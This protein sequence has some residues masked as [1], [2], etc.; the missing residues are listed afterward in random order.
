MSEASSGRIRFLRVR[1]E[2]ALIRSVLENPQQSIDGHDAV[3][4]AVGQYQA[5]T[6]LAV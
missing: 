2:V 6:S 4:C 3:P 1:E 5:H